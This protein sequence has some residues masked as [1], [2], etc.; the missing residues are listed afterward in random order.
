MIPHI[1]AT[2]R[3]QSSWQAL[4]YFATAVGLASAGIVGLGL[5][6]QALLGALVG[7]GIVL[8]FNRGLTL[9]RRVEKSMEE[10]LK[11]G[12][13]GVPEGVELV[14]LGPDGRF[15]STNGARDLL[16]LEDDVTT[17]SLDELLKQIRSERCVNFPKLLASFRRGDTDFVKCSVSIQHK[18]ERHFQIELRRCVHTTP[19]DSF[20]SIGLLDETAMKEVQSS[21]YDNE[22]KLRLIFELSPVGLLWYTEKK[23]PIDGVVSERIFNPAHQKI[24]GLTDEEMAQDGIFGK[25]SHPDDLEKQQAFREKLINREI[26]NYSLEKRYIRKNGKTVW[27]RATWHRIWDVVGDGFQEFCALVDITELKEATENLRITEGRLRFIFESA[28]MGLRWTHERSAPEGGR[29]VKEAMSNPAHHRI[30]GLS[31]TEVEVEGAFMNITHPDDLAEQKRLREKMESRELDE[32]SLD[33]RYIRPNGEITWVRVSWL[34][35]WDED[36]KGMQELSAL[37]DITPIKRASELVKRKEAQLRF[38]FESAPIGLYWTSE[39][40][41]E[42]GELVKERLFNPSHLAITGLKKRDLDKPGIYKRISHPDELEKQRILREKM[43]NREIEEF[44]MEKRYLHSNG[45]WVWVEATWLRKW[46]EDL[47]GFQEVC[48][49][50]DITEQKRNAAILGRSIEAAEAAN[51]AKS[52]FLAMMS[53]EIRTPMN[54]IIGMTS[55]LLGTDLNEDQ[56]DYAKTIRSSSDSLLTIINEILDF[57]KIESGKMEL[58]ETP[59]DLN[60]CVSGALDLMV[61]P[62]FEKGVELVYDSKGDFPS[63]VFGD[64]TRLRQVIVNLLGNALKFT[65]KGDVVLKMICF[66]N[67]G[68]ELVLEFSVID[69]GVGIAANRIDAIFESFSQ[70]DSTTTRKYGG[71]GLGLS[72]S[73]RL[74][75]LMGGRMWVVSQEGV[76]S[77]FS[78]TANVKSLKKDSVDIFGGEE[79][80]KFEGKRV[81]IVDDNEKSR[82]VLSSLLKRAGIESKSCANPSDVIRELEVDSSYDCLILDSD[83]PE[84]SGPQLALKLKGTENL[85]FIPLINYGPICQVLPEKESKLFAASLHK[86]TNH[87]QLFSTLTKVIGK[88]TIKTNV[89]T[90]QGDIELKGSDVRI[91]LVEDHLINQKVALRMLSSLG[92]KADLAGNGLEALEALG[93]QVYDIVFMDMQ[94]PEMDGLTA[95]EEIV[96]RL[97]NDM[98]RPW[99]IALTANAVIGDR[100]RCFEA[101]MDSYLSKPI[102]AKELEREILKGFSSMQESGRCQPNERKGWKSSYSP[103]SNELN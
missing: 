72:I 25:I 82:D 6:K 42:S 64:P 63:T 51:E 92:Y 94:M 100:E 86:P 78:F 98:E 18:V 7:S 91:L 90:Q 16:Q 73:K 33:K 3:L 19:S 60:E 85:G 34:R 67:E 56:T 83:M 79:S 23:H 40:K 27:V 47:E 9:A 101:G 2:V 55:L 50:V 48:T 10:F 80:T 61:A 37:V 68:E 89:S 54:G 95:T 103:A 84:M 15:V 99:I 62:A 69:S 5:S 102:K 66:R 38:I 87:I 53:H 32:I 12:L 75:E 81:L 49:L 29:A 24:S 96:K 59:F 17:S 30:S 58:E 35:R 41:E 26:S 57:S 31:E 4:A 13:V 36:G 20:V 11:A 77:T 70:A 76:G 14:V 45:R 43:V 44:R 21:F 52:L 39:R 46:D 65:D 22:E 1:P 8:L 97:P 71:T 93:R 28:P 74:A 88:K